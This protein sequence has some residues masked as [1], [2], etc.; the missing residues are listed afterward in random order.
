MM[1]RRLTGTATVLAWWPGQARAPYLPADRTAAI[2]DRRIRRIVAHAA[3][4]VPHY[5]DLFAAARIDPRDIKGAG[6]LDQL[7][8]LSR[9][10]VRRDPARFRSTAPWT[11]GALPLLSG[12]TTGEP[13]EV[14]HDRRS[15]LSNIAFGERERAP[16]IA[17]C[18]GG[19]RPTELHVGYETSNFRKILQYYADNTRLPAR[20]RR[21]AVSMHAGVDAIAAALDA[22]R[23]DVLT[24]YG[25]FLEHFF[26]AI[27]TRGIQVHAPKVVTYVGE[28]LPPERRAWIERTL[29]AR[30]MSRYCAVEAFKIGYFCEL[31][32]GFH[33]HDDLCHVRIVASDGRT[34]TPGE[35]GEI[36]ISNLFNEATLLLNYPMGD[37]A[38]L[39]GMACPC[40]RTHRLMS[41]VDGRLEDM[42]LL[43]DGRELHPR[44]VWAALRDEREIL[45]YQLI[46][47]A[48]GRFELKLLTLEAGGFDALAARARVSLGVLIGEAAIEIVRDEALGRVE[49]SA[50]GKFRAVESR[51]PRAPRAAPAAPSA[52]R[53]AA[54]R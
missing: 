38:A 48:I 44:A 54:G 31:G 12:G 2:R 33:L 6:Q 39:T 23:P 27:E 32:S 9:D 30:V 25:G 42:L 29:G 13:L 1:M 51:L 28:R 52:A 43:G 4:W 53:T 24:A 18:G 37:L 46:Q 21:R 50:R 14:H 7:P 34:C 49:R 16:V 3:R 10:E 19:F 20:P 36:V 41:E 11:A 45:Q 40:G 17:L 22:E 47:H 5:R 35:T 8:L 15:L 26:R